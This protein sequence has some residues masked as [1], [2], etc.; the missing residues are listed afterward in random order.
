MNHDHVGSV[1][2]S[3]SFLKMNNPALVNTAGIGQPMTI[4]LRGGSI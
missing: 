2:V 1:R 4:L 3:V